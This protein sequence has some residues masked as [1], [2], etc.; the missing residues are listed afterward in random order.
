MPSSGWFLKIVRPVVGRYFSQ[1]EIVPV[2]SGI[3][4]RRTSGSRDYLPRSA[5]V[6]ALLEDEEAGPLVRELHRMQQAKG[7]DGSLEGFA[8]N[9]VDWFSAWCTR[10][11][12]GLDQDFERKRVGRTWAY[13]ARQSATMPPPPG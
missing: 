11:L 4:C 5:I 8:G 7:A 2:I 12:Y 13:R 9:M 1:E 3:I 6:A 10:G